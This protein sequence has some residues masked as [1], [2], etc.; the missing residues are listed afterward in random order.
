MKAILAALLVAAVL[1]PGHGVGAAAA[2]GI[3]MTRVR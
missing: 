2:H 1:A 3:R